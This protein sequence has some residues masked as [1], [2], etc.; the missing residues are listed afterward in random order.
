MTRVLPTIPLETP[1]FLGNTETRNPAEDTRAGWRYALL[2]LGLASAQTTPGC[3]PRPVPP[4]DGARCELPVQTTSVRANA[5]DLGVQLFFVD[6]AD[7]ELSYSVY[8]FDG[9]CSDV[10]DLRTRSTPLGDVPARAGTGGILEYIDLSVSS[11]TVYCYWVE[12]NPNCRESPPRPNPSRSQQ[13]EVSVP[14]APEDTVTTDASDAQ[15]DT[16]PA[17]AAPDD[18]VLDDAVEDTVE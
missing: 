8:R 7:N 18:T 4:N 12:A 3:T 17:D 6:A 11:G 15:E 16:P 14:A 13:I 10:A 1:T 9:R 2:L 5:W